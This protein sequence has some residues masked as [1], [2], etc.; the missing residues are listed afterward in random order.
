M[1]LNCP[2]DLLRLLLQDGDFSTGVNHFLLSIAIGY[3]VLLA[4]VVL[5]T[6]IAVHSNE[7]FSGSTLAIPASAVGACFSDYVAEV[8][9]EALPRQGVRGARRGMV[10]AA[11]VSLRER[12]SALRDNAIVNGPAFLAEHWR[13]LLGPPMFDVAMAEFQPSTDS[14]PRPNLTLHGIVF[15]ESEAWF[16]HHRAGNQ[17]VIV[18]YR[19]ADAAF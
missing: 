1:G 3:F 17:Y 7:G 14:I 15:G 13:I 19:P 9:P 11:R 18:I 6:P 10:P 16:K 2:P 5:A 8:T 12:L 4:A